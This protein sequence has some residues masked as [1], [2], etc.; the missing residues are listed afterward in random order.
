MQKSQKTKKRRLKYFKKFPIFKPAL[1]NQISLDG[2]E[3]STIP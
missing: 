2:V 3:S 1:A